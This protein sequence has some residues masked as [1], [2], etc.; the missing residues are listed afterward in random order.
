MSLSKSRTWSVKDNGDAA[1]KAGKKDNKKS[2]QQSLYLDPQPVF[3]EERMDMFD[4]LKSEY[5]DKVAS[6]PRVPLKIVLKDG[7][8]KQAVSWETTPMDIAWE[9]PNLWVL[10]YVSQRSM[11]NYGIWIDHLRR[12]R[13]RNQTRTIG[14]RI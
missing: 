3:I 4:R 11:A 7:A 13:R 2:K 1:A 14:F 6:L 12:S 9:F 10:N 8:I 5:D